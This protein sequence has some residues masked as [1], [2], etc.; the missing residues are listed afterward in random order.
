MFLCSS[1]EYKD[2]IYK[3]IKPEGVLRKGR[4][5]FSLLV[6]FIGTENP[7]HYFNAHDEEADADDVWLA[8]QR[9]TDKIPRRK[10][11]K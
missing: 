10:R 5:T 9:G 4:D 2:A 8:K 3:V 6:H 1:G 11:S 7:T